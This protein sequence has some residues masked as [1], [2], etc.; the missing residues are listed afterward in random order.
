MTPPDWGFLMFLLAAL[1]SFDLNIDD[2]RCQGYDNGSN[3]KGK[4]QGV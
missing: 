2:V 3:M 1:K 4:H